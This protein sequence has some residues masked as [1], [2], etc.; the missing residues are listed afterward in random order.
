VLAITVADDGERVR[1]A[2]P[3]YD[4]LE[5]KIDPAMYQASGPA[6]Q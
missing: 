6:P 1:P 3:L 4:Q 5:T 2:Q